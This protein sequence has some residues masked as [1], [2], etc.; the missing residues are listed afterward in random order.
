MQEPIAFSS[1][2][3]SQGR[4]ESLK[5]EIE[6]LFDADIIEESESPWS[7]NVV[8]V[9][10]EDRNFR[11]CVD[12]WKLNAVMKFN[13]FVLPR[14]E[15]ILYTPKSSIYMITLDLQSGYWRISIVLED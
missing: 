6:K 9:P 5:A 1:C 4:R 15:D 14:I 7:S 8:L 2:R 11:L 12:C 10:K 13:E 3:L